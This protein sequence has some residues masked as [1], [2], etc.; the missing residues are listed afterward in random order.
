VLEEG[1]EFFKRQLGIGSESKVDEQQ[2]S[3]FDTKKQPSKLKGVKRKVY[4]P[5]EEQ[6]SKM[7]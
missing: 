2:D 3:S 4:L 1:I 6:M 7:T 5:A